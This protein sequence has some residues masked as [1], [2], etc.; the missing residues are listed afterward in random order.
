MVN[1]ETLSGVQSDGTG[2]EGYTVTI[3]T[4]TGVPGSLQPQ[5]ARQLQSCPIWLVAVVTVT[6]PATQRNVL[7]LQVGVPQAPLPAEK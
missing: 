7:S 5:G 3:Y 6:R 1:E 4:H 2:A